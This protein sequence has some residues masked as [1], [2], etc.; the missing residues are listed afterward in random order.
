MHE[1]TIEEGGSFL[2]DKLDEYLCTWGREKF[3][4]AQLFL[5]HSP[6]VG[7]PAVGLWGGKPAAALSQNEQGRRTGVIS[8]R[9][10]PPVRDSRERTS[11]EVVTPPEGR[12]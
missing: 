11:A 8:C 1:Q 9:L 7:S 6:A 10:L 2:N 4:T 5:P 12:K 3:K